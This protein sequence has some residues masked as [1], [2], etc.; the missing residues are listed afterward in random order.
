MPRI[1]VSTICTA[2]VEEEWTLDVTD[3]QLAELQQDQAVALD[4]IEHSD[5][6]VNVENMR[7]DHETD[8][9]VRSFE[10]VPDNYVT[11]RP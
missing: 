6:Y 11:V 2:T 8:R 1:A 7:T 3:E 9:M 10:V 4:L 5:V